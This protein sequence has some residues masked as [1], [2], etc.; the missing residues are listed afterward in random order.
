M[1]EKN[2]E[3]G[4]TG[5]ETLPDCRVTDPLFRTLSKIK[6]RESVF[7]FDMDGVIFDSE[8]LYLDCC[9]EAADKLGMENITEVCRRC[10]GVTTAVTRNI[11]VEAYRDESLVEKFR[12]SSV[13]LF[14]EKYREGELKEKPGVRELLTCLKKQGRKLAVA[15]STKT[16][17]VEKELCEAGIRDFFDTL[18]G[19]EQ[20][21]R[22]KPFP[23]I[24]L[25]A[26]QSLGAEPECCVV[27]EDSYNGIRAAKAAGMT[28]IM[29]PDQL[30]PDEE[31][32]MLA[33]LIVP[34]LTVI[35]KLLSD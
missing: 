2:R 20:V 6:N 8:R 15:S 19:G 24:F 27:V 22:S 21:S 29:V 9:R 23:D 31:M 14:L 1:R 26:A 12:E 34:S 25:S 10:I 4:K 5:T 17:I 35:K 32:R 3:N 33:D 7:L 28:A 11:L 30:E 18:T 13:G 16:E